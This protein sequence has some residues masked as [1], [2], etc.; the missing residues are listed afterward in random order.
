MKMFSLRLSHKILLIGF[1]GLLGLVV[2]GA[3]YLIGS[4]SQ[5]ASRTVAEDAR[6]ISAL[7]DKLARDLLDARRAEKDFMLRHDEESAKRHASLTANINR[8]IDQLGASVRAGELASLADKVGVLAQGFGEYRKQ[9]SALEQ[10]EIRLGL[11]EKLGLSG[12]LRSS[13]HD[14]EA[15]LKETV[16]RERTAFGAVASSPTHAATGE[17]TS[18]VVIVEQLVKEQNL[19]MRIYAGQAIS[20]FQKSLHVVNVLCGLLFL[21]GW[22]LSLVGK[23]YDLGLTANEG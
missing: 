18:A 13:V 22:L 1:V 3:I 16:E 15:K 2:F 20:G 12:A 11:N 9:F 6:K 7:N 5:D 10:N 8:N 19:A 17:F 14:I 23:L 4:A 21:S